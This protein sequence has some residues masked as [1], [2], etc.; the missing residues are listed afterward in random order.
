M[1]ITNITLWYFWSQNETLFSKLSRLQTFFAG[2]RD[3]IITEFGCILIGSPQT[4]GRIWIFSKSKK[5][6]KCPVY[7]I[8]RSNGRRSNDRQTNVLMPVT[9]AWSHQ[10]FLSHFFGWKLYVHLFFVFDLFMLKVLWCKKIRRKTALKILAKLTPLVNLTNILH[11]CFFYNSFARSFLYLHFRFV[12]FWYKNIGAKA[13]LKNI[14]EIDTLW[15]KTD[16]FCVV[17]SVLLE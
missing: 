1:V 8:R 16:K 3:F 11:V 5:A 4:F 15:N 10:H 13:A 7:V 14:V 9:R 12:L 6:I 17:T 2:H